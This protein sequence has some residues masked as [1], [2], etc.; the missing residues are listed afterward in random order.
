MTRKCRGWRGLGDLTVAPLT[1]VMLYFVM[2]SPSAFAHEV[3]P[4]YLELRQTGPETYD[5][6]WKVPGRGEDLRLGL[7]VELPAG[8]ANVTEPRSSFVNNAF[9]ERWSVQRK[10]GLTGGTIHIAG[11]SSTMTD[12]LVRLERLD[13]TTQVTRLAPSSPSFIVEAAPNAMQVAATYLWLGVEHILLGIDHLLFI[14][15]LLFI[16]NNR[17]M[18]MKTIS[19]FTVAHSMTLAIATLGYARAPAPPLTA[20]IALSILFLGPEIVRAQRGE[21]SLTIRHPWVVAFAFGLLHGFG[22]ASG[23]TTMGL[24]RAEIPVALLLFNLGVEAGQLLFVIVVLLLERA[25]RVLEV[26]LPR[27]LD[28]LPAYAVGSL[29]AFWT[30]QRVM[31]MLGGAR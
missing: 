24:P 10:D 15:G 16:V 31:M 13:G 12:V 5:L 23:L 26:R 1:F 11:L 2:L 30:I 20:A 22:F 3:R 25:F 8:C 9:T 29:G 6:L 4:A 7:H 18:L 27:L 19:S 28:A 17:W 14:L 21:T